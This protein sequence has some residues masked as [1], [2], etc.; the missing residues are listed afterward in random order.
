MTYKYLAPSAYLPFGHRHRAAAMGLSV[1]GK[2]IILAICVVASWQEETAVE[3]KSCESA[4]RQKPMDVTFVIDA[5]SSIWPDNF[6]MGLWFVEDFVDIFQVQ[7]DMVRVAVVSYGDRVY[8][9]DAFSFDKYTNNVDLKKAITNIPYRAGLA[10]E[11][12]AGIKYM[13]ETF[14]PQ[15]RQDLRK[16]CI[17]L[18]DGNSQKPVVTETEARITREAGVEM[19]VVGVGHSV[20]EEELRNIA[21]VDEHVFVV[22]SYNLLGTIRSRLA[23]ETCDE[24][25]PEPPVVCRD[26]P[27][28]I[29]FV[30]DA[31][32]SIGDKNFTLGMDFIKNFVTTFEVSPQRARF[33]VITYGRGTYDNTA[34]DLDAYNDEVGVVDAI[35]SIPYTAGDYTDTGLGIEFMREKQML[36]KQRAHAVHIAIVMTDGQSQDWEKTQKEA[37]KAR[38]AGISMFAIGV[39]LNLSQKELLGIAGDQDRVFT[40]ADYKALD[41]IRQDLDDKT[42]TIASV[43]FHPSGV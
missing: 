43:K 34:F 29:S 27:I 8:T 32:S 22:T 25:P 38:D 37:A 30:I 23:F 31:S 1:F 18:T 42:C 4:C 35:T 24:N 10:T 3:F 28:D 7:P 39:G 13:R 20:T 14:L 5:S 41:T 17:V 19:F 16:V 12:G 11:T 2:V 21:G 36:P 9:E 40:V 26:N 33:S 6:T 15:A